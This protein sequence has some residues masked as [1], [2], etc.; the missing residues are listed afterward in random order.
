[1]LHI[2]QTINNFNDKFIVALLKTYKCE[3]Y[4]RVNVKYMT[5]Y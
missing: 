3:I 2:C 5:E 4:D 1:M